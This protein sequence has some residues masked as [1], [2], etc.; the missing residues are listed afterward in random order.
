MANKKSLEVSER[1]LKINNELINVRMDVQSGKISE[2]NGRHRIS[3]LTDEYLSL[4]NSS[5]A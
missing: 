2:I 4:K 5:T 1:L 3:I